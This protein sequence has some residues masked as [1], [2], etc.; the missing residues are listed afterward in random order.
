[1]IAVEA[2]ESEPKPLDVV[3]VWK[4][5]SPVEGRPT[6]DGKSPQELFWDIECDEVLWGGQAGGGKSSA[7]IAFP[8]KWVHFGAMRG[9]IFRRNVPDLKDLADKADRLYPAVCPA[10]SRRMTPRLEWTFPS[11]GQVAL[12]HCS[13]EDDWQKYQGWE[14]NYLGFDELTQFTEDQYTMI[15]ARLRSAD[16]RIPTAVRAT[17]NPGGQG[18]A[19][20]FKRWGPWLDPNLKVP[21]LAHRSDEQGPLPPAKPGEILHVLRNSDSTESFYREPKYD[22]S[23]RQISRTRTF[24]PA[25]LRDN[26]KADANYDSVLSGIA[27]RVRRLQ[28]RDGNWLVKTVEGSLFKGITRFTNLPAASAYRV[29]YGLDLA[30]SEK[31]QGVDWSVIIRGVLIGRDICLLNMV[32]S[33]VLAQSFALVIRSQQL[34]QSQSRTWSGPMRWFY[35]GAEK[36]VAGL[37]NAN[38]LKGIAQI[39]ALP[40]IAD[41]F[42]RAQPASILW[43]VPQD[44]NGNPIPGGI[45]HILVPDDASPFYGPWVEELLSEVLAFTGDPKKDDN[46]DIVDAL[47]ALVSVLSGTTIRGRMAQMSKYLPQH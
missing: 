17:T 8:L 6:Y 44:D 25:A 37:I 43:N 15:C 26:P 9:L 41:K 4:P 21:T 20:V 36:G 39:E 31:K 13:A 33:Q 19:W 16:P 46:D 12:T 42:V 30:Y 7:L 5:N 3:A 24:I 2:E 40:A 11:G 23:G 1:M 47:A 27:D 10:A 14:V 45:G 34:T 18:H 35:A 22:D 38:Y 28:W 32:R 29:G